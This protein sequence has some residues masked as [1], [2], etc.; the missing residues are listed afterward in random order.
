MKIIIKTYEE[1]Q[2]MINEGASTARN[3]AGAKGATSKI[4]DVSLNDICYEQIKDN[5][6]YGKFGEF[7]LVI[8]KNTGYFNATKLCT[9]GG[10]EF[11]QWKRLERVQE[12]IKFYEN[13]ENSQFNAESCY[14]D[15]QIGN[16]DDKRCRGDPHGIFYEVKQA[17][18]GTGKL[19]TGQ[20]VQK[21]FI[22]DIASWIS[23]AFYF[24]CSKIVNYF[25][26]EFYKKD[27]E[28]KEQQLKEANKQILDERQRA[29]EYKERALDFQT[30]AYLE[31][32]TSV[33]QCCE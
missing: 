6:Y 24:K 28:L 29:D 31:S 9:D 8:D 2:N 26:I 3:A 27:L 1:I 33:S 4:K 19:V 23:P 14:E 5:F 32:L 12:L 7:R 25:F 16:K 13:H 15:S 20:Y 18:Y 22:L 17:N 11:R 10:K 21:E 30:L